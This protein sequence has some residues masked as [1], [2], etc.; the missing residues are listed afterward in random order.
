MKRE[1]APWDSSSIAKKNSLH[2]PSI[3]PSR[4]SYR[5]L[6]SWRHPFDPLSLIVPYTIAMY[7]HIQKL[8]GSEI[9]AYI[10]FDD[11]P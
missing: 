4:T 9:T 8:R 5:T 6:P 3:I 11:R 10:Q 2:K 7:T 1:I